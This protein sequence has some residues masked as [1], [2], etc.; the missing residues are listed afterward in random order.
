MVVDELHTIWNAQLDN[1]KH[2]K[3]KRAAV[4]RTAVRLNGTVPV[5]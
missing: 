5:Q 2:L 1:E 4:R 3:L